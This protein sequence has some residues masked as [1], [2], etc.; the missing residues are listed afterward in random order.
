MSVGVVV[1]ASTA[2]FP[3][4]VVTF[5]M[6]GL[7]IYPPKTMDAA[8]I[9]PK[10]ASGPVG[11]VAPSAPSAPVGPVGAEKSTA[12]QVVP[13]KRQVLSPTL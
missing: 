7:A 13:L 2:V 11:P 6:F 5:T 8:I 9:F 4:M 3:R 1:T 10:G 12:S